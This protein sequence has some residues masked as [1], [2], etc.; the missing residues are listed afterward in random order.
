MPPL[1]RH[2]ALWALGLLGV[3]CAGPA[4][5]ALWPVEAR[6]P[7][8]A[9]PPSLGAL[10]VSVVYP[11]PQERIDAAGG[12][13]W[14][15]PV[16]STY[17]VQSRDS[18]FAFGTVGRGDAQVA[19]NGHAVPVYPTGGWIAWLPLPA[20][21]TVMVIDV[22]AVA[23]VDT[24]RLTMMTPI[25]PRFQAP[26]EG[27]WI[28]TTSFSPTGDRWVLPD[29]ELRLAVR[30]APGAAVRLLLPDSTAL[31]FHPDSRPDDLPWGER[32]FGTSQPG[33]RPRMADRYL[34][35][36][37]G[38]L[39][40]DPGGVLE[41][42]TAPA[43][44][45]SSWVWVEAALGADTVR[46]RWPLRVAV[47]DPRAS[48]VVVV[49]DDP[50]GTGTTD[51]ILA[52][53]PTPWG[54]YH[55]F[56]PTGTVAAVSG[57]WGGQLRLRLSRATTAWVDARDVEPLPAGY[58]PP[59]GSARSMRLVPGPA[60]VTLRVPLPGRVPF[61]VDETD[62]GLRLT[63]YGVAAD[64]DWVQ[65]GGTDP[66]VQRISFAQPQSDVTEVTVTLDRPVWGYRAAW[67]GND[68]QL[69]IRRP[70]RI[71]PGSPLKG[72]RIMLDPGHPPGGAIGPTWV[73][74]SD[75]VLQ[76]ALRARALLEAK[77]ARVDLTRDSD[78][79][80][81]L[82]DRLRLA[83]ATDAEVLVSIHANALPDGVNP[84]VNNG[85]SVYYFHPR[86]IPLARALDR[87][88]VYEL[89]FRDL[90]MGRGDLALARPTWMPAAL[91][92][93]LFL[94]LPDQEAVLS[95]REGQERY[96]RGIVNGIEAFLKEHATRQP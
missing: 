54:T 47:L 83:E 24:A 70:P 43:V 28:D 65:Y 89:G 50:A 29:E 93:G 4:P 71:D 25:A 46:A 37:V 79:A 32:A 19:V 38:P 68:L 17:A 55:W 13:W 20:D 6:D 5:T 95:S 53:R 57:R 15:V 23:G 59:T 21:D 60:S 78:R 10:A 1:I 48:P 33:E 52:G 56:F 11:R 51:S 73:R 58:P 42:D 12:E 62:V 81:G 61:R 63:L 87:A 3:A 41:P 69:E 67:L 96:A 82:V 64:M 27:A 9:P 8:A 39:G 30:A 7:P 74:E 66:F 88:L 75:V 94:V 91:T 76:V 31:P 35:R 40:A 49:N 80:V 14:L 77:G 86:S 2:A 84:F 34:A 90:G 22:R 18:T 16:D 45:D 44:E 26:V 36:Y 72:R 92:E 85:T